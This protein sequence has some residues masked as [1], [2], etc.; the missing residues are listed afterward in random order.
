MFE[1]LKRYKKTAVIFT[2]FVVYTTGMLVSY[3]S[4]QS[5]LQED[6]LNE[7][8][9]QTEKQAE[10]I[11]YFFSERRNDL[12]DLA[13]S[14]EVVNFFGNRD[15]GMSYE[16]GLGINVQ[17]IE[18]EFERLLAHKR[19]GTSQIYLALALIDSDDQFVAFTRPRAS[20]ALFREALRSSDSHDSSVS[21]SADNKRILFTSPIWAKNL[22]RG[23]LVAWSDPDVVSTL[24][25][26]SGQN[27]LAPRVVTSVSLPEL[28]EGITTEM[29]SALRKSVDDLL[30]PGSSS[31]QATASDNGGT[32]AVVRVAI[33]GSPFSLIAPI[34]GKHAGERSMPLLFLI[35]AGLV[36]LVVLVLAVLDVSERKRTEEAREAARIE[37][38]RLARLRSEFLANMSHEIRTPLNGV[39]GLAQI[40]YRDN[41]GRPEVLE[42]FARI[43]D[44][45]KLLLGIVN[46]VLDFS[47]IEAGK[48]AIERAPINLGRIIDGAAQ[49]QSERASAKGLA[50]RIDKAA[51]LPAGC[52]GDPIRL[53]Q[54]LTNLLS[55]AVKFTEKGQVT[56]SANLAGDRL[57]FR[58][59]DTGVGMTPEQLGR[60]FAP[61]EQAD[62]STTRRFGGT[63]LGLAITKR[64]VD[65]MSGTIRVES[66]L[67]VGTTFEVS[68]PYAPLPENAEPVAAVPAPI[69]AGP[70]LS[71]IR[72]LVAEDNEIN[73]IVLEDMLSSEG[74]NVTLVENG[75]QAVERVLHVGG[76]AFDLVLMDIQM[77]EMDGY[78]A[79]RLILAQTP[80]LPVVAQTAHA[81]SDEMDRCRAA[82]MVDQLTKPIDCER[83]VDIVR[84]NA[85]HNSGKLPEPA[86][87]RPTP[88]AAGD[89]DL[90]TLVDWTALRKRYEHKPEFLSNLLATAMSSLVATPENL[91][92]ALRAGDTDRTIFLAHSLKGVAGNLMAN[93]LAR[94]AREAELACR[95]R[96]AEANDIAA[97]LADGADDLVREIGEHLVVK[98]PAET[99][100]GVRPSIH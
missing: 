85:R 7:V 44:A 80:D 8:R 9:L 47:K 96:S 68:L 35:A 55:N 3:Y 61:F 36:P 41:V 90:A 12:A 84:R 94:K 5:R 57:E 98:R 27:R 11:S 86:A 71:G 32:I 67:G 2:I 37:A 13:A 42:T 83:L 19:L 46:D 54:I 56:L 63:G 74:A 16:Y 23:Q 6:V 48:L 17:T 40:G 45:G 59:S 70:R 82:G 15:L 21:L 29:S 53:A 81:L 77:P 49:M 87:A 38:E 52:L 58:I 43:L 26:E 99:G 72:V 31:G 64:L 76:E 25:A 100:D 20:E 18:T 28:P 69:T 1:I 30:A 24:I 79:A 91:R 97:S 33:G 75:K 50:L 14:P 65:L 60:L 34:T 92:L 78:E 4:A 93:S 73:R 10:A 62:S 22:Y 88:D 89:S 51:G 66:E 39:L 95:S